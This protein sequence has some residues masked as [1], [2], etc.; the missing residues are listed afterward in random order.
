M[1]QCLLE[2]DTIILTGMN[3]K[4]FHFLTIY[5]GFSHIYGGSIIEQVI[6]IFYNTYS[7][8]YVDWTVL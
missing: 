1:I 7:V 8:V 2:V 4:G 5:I 3:Y 6:N